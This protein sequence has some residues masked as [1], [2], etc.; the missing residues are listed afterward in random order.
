MQSDRISH[1]R[2]SYLNFSG[3]FSVT[4]LCYFMHVTFIRST[5]RQGPLKTSPI[6]FVAR[7]KGPFSACY[8]G[9]RRRLHAGKEVVCYTAVF[10]VV[11]QRSSPLTAAENRTTLLSRDYL[12]FSGRCSRHVCGMVTPPITALLLSLPHV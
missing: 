9:N 2:K 7:G 8:K 12:P 5:N 10:S 4:R 3:Y 6:S 11:T 1:E